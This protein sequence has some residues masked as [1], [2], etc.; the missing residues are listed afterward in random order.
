[1]AV[2]SAIAEFP[3]LIDARFITK[4][5]NDAGI[6]LVTLFIN[7]YE[8]PVIVDDW[9]PTNHD[10]LAFASSK[11]GE[12]WVM[13]LEKAWAKLHG[14]YTRTEGGKAEFAAQHLLGTPAFTINHKETDADAIWPRLKKYD[15]RDFIMFS[16]SNSG[17]ND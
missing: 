8:S 16:S 9:F 17:T 1:L 15:E 4:E 13:I 2:L 5:R 7:G 10:R 6:Y 14:S 11:D 3:E 12:L